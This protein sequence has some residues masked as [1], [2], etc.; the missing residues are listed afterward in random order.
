MTST[1][2]KN[3][4][5]LMNFVGG[6][7]FMAAGAVNQAGGFGDIMSKTQSGGNDVS[8]QSKPVAKQP[9]KDPAGSR[10]N[11]VK[12][13]AAET[14]AKN[15]IEENEQADAVNRAG[16][17]LVK[18]IAEE[19][20]IPEEEVIHAMESLGLSAYQLLEPNNLTQLMLTLSGEA[21]ASVFL[22]NENLFGKLQGILR[23]AAD[24]QKSLMEE[25]KLS[26][27]DMQ[28]VLDQMKELAAQEGENS[29][30]PDQPDADAM[31]EN[32]SKITVEVK[33]NG[34]SVQLSA[35]ENGN[36]EKTIGVVKESADTA[37]KPQSENQQND[38]A[39]GKSEGN[40]QSGNPLID[41]LLQDKTQVQ[42]AQAPQTVE[43]FFSSQ[44][45]DIMDQIMDYM[46]VQLK[47]GMDQLEMQLHPASL[48]NVHVQIV[49]KG[50]EITAQFHVQNE[51]VKAAIE[52][53]VVELKEN[54]KD[55]GVK[56]EAVQVTV[57]N[58]GFESNLW[59]GQ[60]REENAASQ[61]GRKP[62]RRINLND[63]D[64]LF[65]EEASEEDLLNAQMMEMNGNTLDYTV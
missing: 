37:E 60:G 40:G 4:N 9:V 55:Q 15:E 47:P 49:S 32:A 28:S 65:E 35:D 14:A 62:A 50:G 25:L 22:T 3:V 42:E 6:K 48:G 1:P 2:V 39:K 31:E 38:G 58:H 51:T 5:A 33:V 64:A 27:E 8:S 56:V 20:G 21:D 29:L 57:E 53:Q 59:Q 44:T 52:S 45:Q 13:Q 34:E 12:S 11:P 61:N 23:I 26:P 54:L 19:L 17:E 46:R 18:D 10:K 63:L 24:A 30:Q 43:S 41:A 16:E 36:V 7:N